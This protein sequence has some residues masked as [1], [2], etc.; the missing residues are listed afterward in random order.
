MPH[1]GPIG[2]QDTREFNPVVQSLA[3]HGYAVL[4]VNYRGSAGRETGFLEAGLGAWG[5]G[6]ED[7]IEAALDTVVA[8]CSGP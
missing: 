3:A 7:D 5:K 1:G 4:Q 8:K 2:V 6:I